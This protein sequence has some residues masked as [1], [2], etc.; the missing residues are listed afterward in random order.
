MWPY[1]ANHPDYSNR[2]GRLD[3][4][5]WFT[6]NVRP[7]P[8]PGTLALPGLGLVGVGLSRRRTSN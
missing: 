2:S 6:I 5:G 3:Y 1:W 7:V 8:E 4:Y